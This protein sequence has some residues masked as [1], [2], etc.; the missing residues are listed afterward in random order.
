MVSAFVLVGTWGNAQGGRTFFAG[1]TS[2]SVDLAAELHAFDNDIFT[3]TAVRPLKAGDV[4]A[5]MLSEDQ[6]WSVAKTPIGTDK[7]AYP[8]MAMLKRSDGKFLS[9]F[10]A[11]LKINTD[12]KAGAVL[13]AG[14][15]EIKTTRSIKAGDSI[16]VLFIG[17]R[18]IL[19]V[20]ATD[21]ATKD[22]EAQPWFTVFEGDAKLDERHDTFEAWRIE[23]EYVHQ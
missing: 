15:H 14:S 19:S 4:V 7:V 2:L 1:Q 8:V 12:I 17:W 21:R 11:I 10:P 23:K 16:P 3:C 20:G 13:H 9:V 6:G 5:M 18:S 22:S